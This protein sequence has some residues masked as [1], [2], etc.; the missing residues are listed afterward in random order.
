MRQAGHGQRA[1]W[2]LATLVLLVVPLAGAQRT[3]PLADLRRVWEQPSADA[4]P[5]MRWWWFGPAV[6]PAS[7]D[8]ELQAMADAGLG[9]VEVQPVYPL[10]PDDRGRGLVNH[11]FLSAPFLDA[12]RHSAS[13]ATRLGLR[14]D[15]TL[16]SGWPYGG[17][18]ISIDHAAGR[19]RFEKIPVTAR[20]VPLPPMTTGEQLIAVMLPNGGAE[21]TDLRGDIVWLPEGPLPSEVWVFI[22]GR[23]GMMVKRAAVGAEGYVLDHYDRAALESHL[24]AV[25]TPLLDALR[26]TPP[27]T[28]FCDSLEVFGS[29]W[30]PDFLTEF[31]RRRAYDL[32]PHLG[33][34]VAGTD[35]QAIALRQDWGRTLGELYE[36]RFLAPLADWVHARGSKLRIQ[37]YGIP[38]ATLSSNRLADF[39][40]GEGAQWKTI[41]P[42]R[43]AS[44]ANHLFDR[45][46]T[47]SETWTW[48]HSPSFAATPLDLK[49]EADR[50]FLMGV[51]QLIGHGW[52]STPDGVGHADW[53]YNWRFYAAGAF[54]DRNPWW[55]AMPDVSRYL[56]RVS[57][58]LR[59]GRPMNDVALYLPTSDALGDIKPGTAHLL[60]LL[61]ERIGTAVPGAILDAG[62]GFDLIDDAALAPPSTIEGGALVAGGQRH[63]IIVLPAVRTM[64]AETLARLRA[65]AA[66]G[67]HVIATDRLPE[68]TPGLH[69]EPLPADLPITPTPAASLGT[70]LRGALTPDVQLEPASPDVG[71]HHRRV[72]DVEVYFLANTANTLRAGRLTVR[73]IGR[74]EWW[75][76]LTGATRAAD[77]VV[78]GR[79]TMTFALDLAPYG[80][81]VL[82]VAPGGAPRAVP[83]TTMVTPRPQA[84]DVRGPWTI[85]FP[86]TD[87]APRTRDALASWDA[88]DDTRFFSGVATYEAAVELPALPRGARVALDFGPGQALE[89][90]DR[91]PGMR[92]WLDAP[93]RDAAVIMVNGQRAGAV[94][95]PPFRLDVTGFVRAGRNTLSIR[96]GNTGLN[97]MAGR[98]L[99]D[100]RLLNLRYGERFQPQGMELIKPLPSG[101]VGPVRVEITPLRPR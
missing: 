72:G 64:P 16:G 90:T 54:N 21:L 9:G 56:T 85:A 37:G 81:T 29:D 2:W 87:L 32:R 7:L 1:W 39:T 50:H 14:F 78:V 15:L 76:P 79:D 4:R 43:W 52:P 20:R 60:D 62:F 86:D 88:D 5:M 36:E 74:A 89:A 99:P 41:T 100:Y 98:P 12:V 70:A 48:L 17:P 67:G 3:D 40:D 28:I 93:V 26:D 42:A 84:I 65:F 58:L 13:T 8:R 82:V 91:G 38:P 49:A 11:P 97:H 75:D 22:A 44:S 69:G 46:V 30:T 6:T 25:G 63:R 34:L 71:Q 19:L 83:A 18:H 57:A 55:I 95:C 92:T 73:A 27:T 96:V 45:P 59:Q 51:N 31:R 53:R 23:T 101:L 94:W 10:V 61:R 47:A 33:A 35:A 24:D 80:S 66:A 68:R 77:P